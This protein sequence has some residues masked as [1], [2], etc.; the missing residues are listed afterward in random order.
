MR[1]CTDGSELLASHENCGRVQDEYSLRC[2]PQ[3]L[4]ATAEA[5]AYVESAL[6]PELDAVTDNPL[7]FPDDG[8]V[9]SGGNFHGQPLGLPLDALA[10]AVAEIAGFSERRSYRL[11]TAR[12]DAWSLPPF[13]T[14]DPG[15][16]SGLMILQY[17]A[18][19][20]CAENAV[21][22][23]P[24]GVSSLP[25]SAGQED[26]N[27]MGATSAQKARQA[28]GNA[29]RVVAIELICAGQGIDLRRPLRTGA[30]LEELHARLRAITPVVEDD[31][32]LSADI[33]AVAEAI[34]SGAF[35][36]IAQ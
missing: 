9:V 2:I 29:L 3:V 4:G 8:E 32:S 6:A 14:R 26:W 17:T 16:R 1:A 35:A 28:I 20:L 12:Q 10:I 25:T 13:L 7:V 18:A 19:A 33:E 22:A 27:S 11:L 31:R 15:T 23:H 34:R 30:P 36:G 5:L 21:L 24:A